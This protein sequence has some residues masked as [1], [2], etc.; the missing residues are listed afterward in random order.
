MV[1]PRFQNEADTNVKHEM[2]E[3]K[4]KFRQPYKESIWNEPFGTMLDFC[5]PVI[6]EEIEYSDKL[7]S[8]ITSDEITSGY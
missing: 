6:N 4:L 2:T 8:F 5:Q 7:K 3:S 1:P